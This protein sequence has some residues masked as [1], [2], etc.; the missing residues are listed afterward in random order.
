MIQKPLPN[1]YLGASYPLYLKISWNA[2]RKLF[3]VAKMR[4]WS[5][6]LSPW[7]PGL[8]LNREECLLG[9]LETMN[10]ISWSEGGKPWQEGY[11][12]TTAHHLKVTNIWLWNAFLFL[13]VDLPP[14]FCLDKHGIS[15]HS[16]STCWL[17][18]KW[19]LQVCWRPGESHVD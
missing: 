19:Q 6:L 3:F 16:L 14:L 11:K 15:R 5:H 13:A 10:I 1:L 17:Q 18:P 7:A 2:C 4:E 8:W 12:T 9:S